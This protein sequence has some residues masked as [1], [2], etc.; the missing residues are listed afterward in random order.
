MSGAFLST[1]P[2]VYCIDFSLNSYNPPKNPLSTTPLPAL[3][4]TWCALLLVY[5][6]SLVKLLPFPS[7]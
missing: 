7:K 6:V 3:T 1:V 5:C 2:I 4:V